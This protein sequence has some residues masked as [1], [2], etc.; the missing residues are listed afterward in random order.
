MKSILGM[1]V[2]IGAVSGM[3]AGAQASFTD[4]F[5]YTANSTLPDYYQV[6]GNKRTGSALYLT[7]SALKLTSNHTGG[8]EELGGY[9]PTLKIDTTGVGD[10]WRISAVVSANWY[11]SN[12]L[13]SNY[14][15]I[16][17][18]IS[19]PNNSNNYVQVQIK[20]ES[21]S[22]KD[23]LEV[24]FGTFNNLGGGYSARVET[25]ANTP[26]TI[27][28]EKRNDSYVIGTDLQST[29]IT[30]TS[31]SSNE[32]ISR[33]YE[34]LNGIG[35]LNLA[36]FVNGAAYENEVKNPDKL[37]LSAEF[38][39]LTLEGLNVVGA[40]VPEVTSLGMLG[41]GVAGLLVKSI[42]RR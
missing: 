34:L 26:Y 27:W 6:N 32:N 15:A 40:P 5:S 12:Q 31:S 29:Q 8:G 37:L 21:N 38:D 4:D 20:R 35:G 28:I 36:L 24:G 13:S 19:D 23:Y 10:T 33:A 2:M 3:T 22:Q 39:R 17:F 41:V 30:L 9:V 25:T 18:R 11:G 16:G 42:G 14:P 7:G 1:A